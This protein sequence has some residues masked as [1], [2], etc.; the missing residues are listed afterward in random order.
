MS[1]KLSIATCFIIDHFTIKSRNRVNKTKT[2]ETV[3]NNK[4]KRTD[5][6]Y[7]RIISV[8]ADRLEAHSRTILGNRNQA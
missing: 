6:I 2:V 5:M 8:F 3:G 7:K 1:Y 4:S